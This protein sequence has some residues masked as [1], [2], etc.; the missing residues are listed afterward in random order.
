M[1]NKIKCE[2]GFVVTGVSESHCKSNLKIHMTSSLH[3]KLMKD[4][5]DWFN[6]KN[7][8]EW[9][10]MDKKNTTKKGTKIKGVEDDGTD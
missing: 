9:I 7:P 10:K 5:K 3:K 4:R 6:Q 8:S 2:C 1:R